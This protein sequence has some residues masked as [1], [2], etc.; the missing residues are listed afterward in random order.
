MK[1]ININ[2][3]FILFSLLAM[4]F[5]SCEEYLETP[6]DVNVNEDDVFGSY[7]SYQGYVD[8]M[9]SHLVD[10]NNHALTTTMDIG[11]EVIAIQSWS[12][13]DK[14]NQSN[15]YSWIISHDKTGESLQS[16]FMSTVE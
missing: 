5:W 2:K 4:T 7:L 14:G 15:Y 13:A 12:S 1:S 9:Y 16:N 3:I 11:G 10:Y 8:L 6:A